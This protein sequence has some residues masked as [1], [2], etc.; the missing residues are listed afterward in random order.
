MKKKNEPKIRIAVTIFMALMV[1]SAFAMLAIGVVSATTWS[2]EEGESIQAAVDTANDGDTIIV[3]NGIYTE[4]VNVNKRLTIQSENGSA[5]CIVN[6]SDSSD[7]VFDV[8]RDYVNVSGFTVENAT[9]AWKAG[10][11]LNGREHCNIS[12]NNLR[13]NYHGIYLRSSSNYNTLTSNTANSNDHFGILLYSSSNY[14]TL[15]NNTANSNEWHGICLYSSCNNN[16]LMDNT[17]NLNN[18]YGI[19]LDDS[20]NNTLSNNTANSNYYGILLYSSSN[21][22]TLTNNTANSNDYYGIYLHSSSNNTL[23]NNTANSNDYFGIWLSSSSNNTLTNNTANANN[24]Y[25]IYLYSSSNNNTLTNNTANENSNAG[26]Y[27]HSSSNNNIYNNYFNNTHNAYDDGNNVWNTTKTAGTNVIG[28][29]YL[30]GNYWSDYNGE[31][32][33]GDG[34]GDTLIPYDSKGDIQNGGDWHPLVPVLVLPVH[35]LI[36]NENF[37]TIQAAIDDSD[38]LDGDTI[39]VDPGTY[40]E[41]VDV[42]KSLTIRSTSGNPADTV[43]N[44]SNPDD[45]VFEVRANWVNISGFTVEN[46]TGNNKA[47]IYLYGREHCNISGNNVTN[48]NYGIYLRSSSNNNTLTNNTASN[49]NYGIL[50]SSSSNN[51]LTDNTASNNEYGIFLLSSSSNNTLTDNT[52]LNNYWYGIYLYSSSNNTLTSNTA[53]NSWYGIYL[54]SSSNN[55][56]T[57]NTASNNTNGGIKLSSS[58]SNNIYNN[59]FNNT[60]NAYDGGNNVWNTT[61]TAGTNVIGGPYLGGNYWS[62]Y[63][64]EDTDGDGLGD[65]LIPYDSKGDIQNGGDWHPLVPV[66]VAAPPNITSFAPPSPV[67]DTEGATRTFNI[68]VN[69]TVNVSWQINGMDVQTN[70]SVIEAY[71][72]RTRVQKW[73]PGTSLQLLRMIMARLCRRGHGSFKLQKN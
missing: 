42:T 56:L 9:G 27:L 39:T 28:G 48:N 37:T 41:N 40:N 63:N 29:P 69:Q 18:Y 6:A 51:T 50:L 65:T 61:K 73:E 49:N 21:N 68:T 30:G 71:P 17:A 7:H 31:D 34:L 10:I 72:T 22:N 46:A 45:Y 59:Y 38:T 14:N 26:I 16:T 2:V 11:Y 70:E 13:N 32:T 58:S 20:S 35:N 19:Y 36:T 24:R 47:G 60:H 1:T 33:D 4:N 5:N 67:S 25:G 66:G 23:T 64:G 44:A 57:S 55:T 53:S 62:D 3:K 12:D 52:A 43:V 54:Y 8:Q 15:T